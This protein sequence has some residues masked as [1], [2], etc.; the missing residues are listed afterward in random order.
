M[1]FGSVLA[2][3]S[4]GMTSTEG[5]AASAATADNDVHN[6]RIPTRNLIVIADF[7]QIVSFPG[8]HHVLFR[9]CHQDGLSSFK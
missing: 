4:G 2:A 5:S 9:F 8:N 1:S 6:A 3:T 7:P